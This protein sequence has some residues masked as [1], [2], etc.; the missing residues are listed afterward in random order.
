MHVALL[1]FK[2]LY[3]FYLG[4]L[5][6][7]HMHAITT[8]ILTYVHMHAITTRKERETM[9]L[10]DSKE[11]THLWGVWKEESKREYSNQIII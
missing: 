9:S 11:G 5:M 1:F 7:I 4:I 8:I 2:G 6:Y 10:E 3:R